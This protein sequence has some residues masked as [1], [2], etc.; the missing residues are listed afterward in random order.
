MGVDTQSEDFTVV[1][2][3]DMSGD[4]F[5]NGML[6]SQH[7]RLVA[8]FDHRH[9]FIDPDPDAARSFVERQRLFD[10][11]R[12]SWE[13]YEPGLIGPGGGVFSRQ[14]KSIP[15]S[16][17]M[18][19]ALGIEDT[20]TEMTPPD[21]IRAILRAP[22]DLLFNG[23]IGTYI[24]AEAESDADVGDRANDTVRVNANQL[25]A[26]VIGEGGNLGVTSLGR[27]EFDLCSGRVNTDALDNSAGVD[28]SDHEV[29]IKILV[30]SLVGAGLVEPAQRTEL[31]ASMTDE[32]G[33]LVLTDNSDQN[34]L[35]GTSR[36]N[37]PALLNVHARQIRELEESRGLNRELEALPTSKE[38]RR[39]QDI[40]AGLTSPELATLMAH[41]KLALKEQVLAS[42][43]PDQE[44]FAARLPGYFPAPLR[45]G[46][47]AEIRAHQLRREIITTM[48]VNKVVDTGG[49]TFAYRVTEDAGVD[50][51]DAVRAFA[52]S[53]AIFGIEGTWRRIRAAGSDG[54]PAAVTD[55]MTL[56]LR[57]LLDRS[58][59]WLLNYRPQPL[60]VGAEINRF[61]AT[62]AALAPGMPGWLRG[63]DQA[64]VA[65][66]TSEFAAEGVPQDLAYTVASGLYQYSLLD[67]IDIADIVD[68]DAAE[69]ADTYFALMDYLGTDGLL[70]A[71]SGLPRDDRWHALARLAIRDDIYGSLR[72]LCFDVLAVG[73]T[74]ESGE[75]KIAEWEQGNG[76]RV[77]RARRT[78]SEI[79]QTDARDLATLSVAARQIRSM[80]RTSGAGTSA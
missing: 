5:G 46:F 78:L 42:D 57:R 40:G 50:Y 52:A 4:V 23:G 21:L 19:R 44:A 6:L 20:V 61:A 51:V 11:P 59:R 39:R 60:A 1:G 14:Q 70:T 10:L 55:R 35:M 16:A 9:I 8:A 64:I 69:V 26:K 17:Q 33:R 2:I 15:I 3:G 74:S 37:A 67:V 7:I 38:I 65:K 34:D 48:L 29:N 71:V 49:I 28:C 62:V 54:V 13:D 63:D 12:S 25:R 30:D 72:A 27:V 43:L 36:A 24:K 80:T 66:E 76:S 22:V 75:E 56:D 31:L 58:A 77:S 32:V 18:H 79:Y 68:R 45:E 41:V 53:D 73:E 47:S